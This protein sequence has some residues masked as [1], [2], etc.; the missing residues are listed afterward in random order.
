M[1]MATTSRGALIALA[2][3]G[4]A[5]AIAVIVTAIVAIRL[6]TKDT[7]TASEYVTD[8]GV[9]V[10]REGMR[11]QGTTQLRQLGCD[12]AIVIDMLRLFHDANAVRD[13]EPRYIVT[14]DV[15]DAGG[16]S[17]ER[18][19]ATYFAALGR[20]DDGTV[21]IRIALRGSRQPTCSRLYG[22]SGVDLGAYPLLR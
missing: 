18:A 20:T 3:G 9:E 17:C 21:N 10:G 22:P 16:P 11:A 13:G 8:E 7:G 4:G 2:I 1:L 15:V 6:F 5:A 14:C 12:Q 19:A